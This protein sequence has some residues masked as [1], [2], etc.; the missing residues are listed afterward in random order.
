MAR[1]DHRLSVEC[2]KAR[3]ALLQHG[4]VA[5]GKVTAANA[6]LEKHIAGEEDL[7]SGIIEANAAI[8][9]AGRGQHFQ[10]LMAKH[11]WA[12]VVKQRGHRRFD[13]IVTKCNA[14]GR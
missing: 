6:A 3:K 10:L 5:R 1:I 12:T 7:L 13:G 11:D 2:K 14:I 8:T 9:M 4:M